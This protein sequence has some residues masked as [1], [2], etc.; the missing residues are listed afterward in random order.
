MI[1]LSP[2][3]RHPAASRTSA[4][5]PS[6]SLPQPARRRCS[7]NHESVKFEREGA[8]STEIARER[9]RRTGP[10]EGVLL[11]VLGKLYDLRLR[12]GNGNEPSPQR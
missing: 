12:L 4:L 5:R 6:S 9:R 8:L 10:I 3:P 7:A 1:L 11:F 2:G